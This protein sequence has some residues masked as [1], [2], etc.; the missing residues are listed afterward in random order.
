MDILVRK[1]RKNSGWF[2]FIKAKNSNLDS[3]VF[4]TYEEKTN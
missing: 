4:R 2:F 1:W 3:L